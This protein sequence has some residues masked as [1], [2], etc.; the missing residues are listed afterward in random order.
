M[1]GR[2]VTGVPSGRWVIDFGWSMTEA[3]ASLYE[4]PFQYAVSKIKPSVN[5][6]GAKHTG[7]FGGV[8]WNLDLACGTP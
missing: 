2:D 4:G 5:K 7:R 8:T 1:N 3:E 6:T